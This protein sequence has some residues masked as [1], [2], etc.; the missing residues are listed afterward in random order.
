MRVGG[1]SLQAASGQGTWLGKESGGTD[2]VPLCWAQ[3]MQDYVAALVRAG[4][5][6][7][8]KKTSRVC[9]GMGG[10]GSGLSVAETK[11]A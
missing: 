1:P 11:D 4:L 10:W 7:S 9:L 8:P 2:S 6:E 3:G 5:V